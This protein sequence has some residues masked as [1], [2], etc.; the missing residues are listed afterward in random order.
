M[1]RWR[2]RFAELAAAGPS[3]QPVQ[4]VQNVQ[5]GPLGLD[6]E[7]YEQFEQRTNE[8][9]ELHSLCPEGFSPQRWEL[10]RQG[11]VRFAAEWADRALSLGWTY[12]ELFAVEEPFA[13]VE[14]QGAAWFIGDATV[15]AVTADAITLRSASG[16]TQRLY[17]R[18]LQ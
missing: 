12:D 10:L 2:Q 11:A 17:R 14:L 15:T 5:N 9:R 16:A 18:S 6:S 3:S 4:N 1:N 7:H 13:R 8:P